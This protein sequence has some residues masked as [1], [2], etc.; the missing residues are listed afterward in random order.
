MGEESTQNEEAIF[1]AAIQIE[2]RAEREAYVAEV[3]AGDE[4]LRTS[5]LTLLRYHDSGSFLDAPALETEVSIDEPAPTEGPGATIGRYK[6]LEKIGEGGMA[7]VYMAQQERPIHRKVALKII[8]LGMDT[9]QVI[10]RFEA[11]RQALAM[12]DHPNIAKVLDAGATETGRPYFVME[13]VTG[14]SITAYCDQN[15]LSTR[16]RLD[17]F[18]QVCHAVQHAHQKGIIHRDIKPSNVMVT[19]HGGKSVPKVIDFGIAKATNQRLTEK[20]LFTRYAHVIGTPA[21][22]SPEQA[23][24]SDLDI[25]TRSDIYSLGVLLYELLTGATP[26]GEEGLRK[27]G[28][29]EMQRVIREEDP[30]KPSTRLTTL[31]RTLTR[32]AECRNST[33][34]LLKKAIRGDIDW[35]VMKSLEKDRTRRYE[36]ANQL[37]T[38][39][40]RHLRHETV[41]AGPPGS[42]YR[43]Q[44][45]LLRNRGF[46]AAGIGL[47]ILIGSLML[48]YISWH[49]NRTYLAETEALRH[50]NILAQARES[51]A[52]T[53]YAGAMHKVQSILGSRYVG[54][55]AQLLY[56]GICVEGQHPDKAVTTLENLLHAPP[57]IA[58]A[59]H[60]LLARVYWEAPSG[61]RERFEKAREHQRQ[62]ETMLPAT[63]EA[64]FLRAMTALTIR[65]KL[66]LLD[67]ALRLDRGHYE[68]RRLRAYIYQ[69]SRRYRDLERDAL[70]MT[71]LRP[72]DFL[73]YRMSGFAW[74]R[75]G[76]LKKALD[77]Y[78]T[79]LQLTEDSR[80]EHEDLWARRCEV[81]MDMEEHEQ[82]VIDV[83]S[84]LPILGDGARLQFRKF[85]ALI[86]MG[87]YPEAQILYEGVTKTNPKFCQQITHWSAKYVFDVLE[88]GRTWHPPDREPHGS[89]FFDLLHA[90]RIHQGLTEKARRLIV[91][92]FTARSSPDGKTVAFS[93]GYH[94]FSGVALLDLAT[95]ETEL[96]IAPGKD[97]AW[98][99]DGRYLAFV[100][101]CSILPLSELVGA[102]REHQ[103]R[104]VENEEIWV[105]KADG[106]EPRRLCWG[107]WPHWSHDS[108]RIIYQSRRENALYTISTLD[109]H[110]VPQLLL[111]DCEKRPAL[112]ADERQ[113][114]YITEYKTLTIVELDS[115]AVG[116]EW[117]SPFLIRA[118]TWCP[119]T[120]ELFLGLNDYKTV[121]SGLWVYSLNEERLRKVLPG[122]ILPVSVSQDKKK[123]FFNVGEPLFEV[124]VATLEPNSPASETLGPGKSLTEHHEEIL[125]YYTQRIQSDPS[126]ANLY[127]ARAKRYEWLN[128]SEKVLSDLARYTECIENMTGTGNMQFGVP[129]NLGSPV[130]SIVEE[131]HPLPTADGRSLIFY[132]R[133]AEG[134]IDYWL[135]TR[136]AGSGRWGDPTILT[137]MANLWV[138]PGLVTSDGRECYVR[139]WSEETSSDICVMTR[140]SKDQPWGEPVNLGPI[141]NTDATEMSPAV[142]AD[143]LELYFSGYNHERMRPN[144]QGESD[145]WVTRR[146]NRR[147]AWGE[148]VNLGPEINSYR[149]DC[150]P[151]LSTNGLLLFF[152]SARPGGLGDFDIWMLRRSSIDEPWGAP[153]NLGPHVNSPSA[154]Y[155][156]HLS[157]DGATLYFVSRRFSGQGNTDLWQVSV[158]SL[159][160]EVSAEK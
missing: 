14:V 44:K 32:I 25:D 147:A 54:A 67:E 20:T 26:F 103:H 135:S 117:L 99:P 11:E 125:D 8:K 114:A 72:Q 115:K 157:A 38:D 55:E 142:T 91:D 22:M 58:G 145:L 133:N 47:T 27:I 65:E 159:G 136:E 4:G 82:V 79:A 66:G 76:R 95:H 108:E 93:T 109:D 10:A 98:S 61:D 90:E 144:G 130:N 15:Q 86:A 143:G 107:S 113:V 149:N 160:R 155:Y 68:A 132:R 105:M 152:D 96:L 156:P 63:A 151:S 87:R 85:C 112:S 69:A 73:G 19:M 21:Y 126:N 141:V 49:Q 148:P 116:E 128:E 64:H 146:P 110:P 97:P 59:A 138:I 56:A 140:A 37:C 45:W 57:E 94:G 122:P 120:H 74:N 139:Q 158:I 89:A 7:V 154:E 5:V 17:L 3:C 33:P 60:A 102:E 12:M 42:L 104:P 106:T 80:A 121:G 39:I 40:Q 92:A 36:T 34:A 28:Y 23:E 24:L 6:L 119:D 131:G 124:W 41:L 1:D 50:R 46:L 83:D 70:V 43:L 31:G 127:Y 150:R 18:I 52:R 134:T 100:R 78:T 101:D 137:S 53:D 13:L 123:L 29:L 81:L 62:A 51:L 30:P 129:M 75:L 16:D 77:Y 9:K 111:T 48:A 35:I 153:I 2:D 71:A 118:I 88:A 84:V